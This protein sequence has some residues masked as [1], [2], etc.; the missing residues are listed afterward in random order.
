MLLFSTE[1]AWWAQLGVFVPAQL[2]IL[3]LPILLVAFALKLV[4]IESRRA[5]QQV[6]R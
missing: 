3:S 1:E 6:K 2:P 4:E 5:L